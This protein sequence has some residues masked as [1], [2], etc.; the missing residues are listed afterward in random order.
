MSPEQVKRRWFQLSALEWSGVLMMIFC[1]VDAASG[2]Q[3]AFAGFFA[4]ALLYG[5]FTLIWWPNHHDRP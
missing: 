2:H 3:W 5:V 4:A 1:G